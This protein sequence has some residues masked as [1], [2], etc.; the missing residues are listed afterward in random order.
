MRV[1]EPIWLCTL[2]HRPEDDGIVEY[3]APKMFRTRFNYITVQ[4]ASGYVKTLEFGKDIS[5]TWTVVANARL[6]DEVFHE[7]DVL[8]VDGNQPKIDENYENGQGA[9]AIVTSVRKQ[10]L[11]IYIILQ[12]QDLRGD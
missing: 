3:E 8:Y 4:P 7:G 11:A 1:G 6:F 12:K 5:R 10:N 2:K 9:N